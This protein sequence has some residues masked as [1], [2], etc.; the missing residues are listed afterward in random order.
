MPHRMDTAKA[1]WS[2]PNGVCWYERVAGPPLRSYDRCVSQQPAQAL[3]RANH[4]VT[5]DAGYDATRRSRNIGTKKQGHGQ[6]NDLVV[7]AVC[8]AERN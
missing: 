8:H 2:R 3:F 1:N 4:G 5:V 6:D 7:P